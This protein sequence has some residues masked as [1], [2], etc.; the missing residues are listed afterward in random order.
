MKLPFK[1]FI[2]GV[3]SVFGIALLF[4]CQSKTTQKSTD[5]PCID[6]RA[7]LT[8]PVKAAFNDSAYDVQYIPLETTDSSLIK[9]IDDC[10]VTS[11][12]IYIFNRGHGVKQFDRQGHYIRDIGRVGGGPGEYDLPFQFMHNIYAD[13]AH[14]RFY[15]VSVFKTWVFTLDG[16]FIETFEHGKGDAKLGVEYEYKIGDNRW[17]AITHV[18]TPFS[19][20]GCF[21]IGVFTKQGDTI[22]IK[23]DDFYRDCVPKEY[24]GFVNI[25]IAWT[26]NSVLFKTESC[27]TVFRLSPDAI[28]PAY[29]LKLDNSKE[30]VIQGLH[31]RDGNRNVPQGVAKASDILIQDLLETPR[32]LYYRFIV[33]S[34]F[35]VGSFDRMTKASKVEYAASSEEADSIMRTSEVYFGSIGMHGQGLKG[36]FWGKRFGKELAQ[37]YMAPEWLY[38]KK[39]GWVTGLDSLKEDDNPVVMIAKLK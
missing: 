39:E 26:G 28:K 24:S 37:I 32:T 17:A 34:K 3:C 38:C 12:Y 10:V 22:A 27:D 14:N 16:N 13:E 21:G 7:A 2:K 19:I 5:I 8:H 25:A 11:K 30:D 20:P 33:N 6:V 29:V 36:P 4:S 35:Y 15:V 31:A 18:T 9:A 1:T 23:K